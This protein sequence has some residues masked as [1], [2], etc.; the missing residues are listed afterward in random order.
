MTTKEVKIPIEKGLFLTTCP[1]ELKRY[2]EDFDNVIEGANEYMIQRR[3][4]T[5]LCY[6]FIFGIIVICSIFLITYIFLGIF[7]NYII[8]LAGGPSAVV[9]CC[10]LTIT[11]GCTFINSNDRLLQRV[12]TFTERQKYDF[13]VALK[14]RSMEING[15]QKKDYCLVFTLPDE[16]AQKAVNP[17]QAD[18]PQTLN[19][20]SGD[21]NAEVQNK[22]VNDPNGQFVDTP[23]NFTGNSSQDN[24]TEFKYFS[25]DP[26]KI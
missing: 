16:E 11:C 2:E 12:E 10:I 21:H 14:Y 4:N 19:E 9:L 17:N 7:L 24:K 22:T 1:P 8:I 25:N 13:K 18:T 23:Q 26:D 20:P 3:R 15:R 6:I 5:S